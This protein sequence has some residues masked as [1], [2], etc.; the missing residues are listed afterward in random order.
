MSK[1]EILAE[2][3]KLSSQ[4]RGEILE[5]LWRLEEAAGLTDYEKYALNDAQAAYD[6]NPNA[7]SPWSEV[8]ARLR[9]RA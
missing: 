1:S 9:K 6:A 7:V 3:P 5:Q 4:E 8:Q 2:L